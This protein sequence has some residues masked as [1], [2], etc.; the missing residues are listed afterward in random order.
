[1]ACSNDG[2]L[3]NFSSFLSVT[4]QGDVRLRRLSISSE[5]SLTDCEELGL[6]HCAIGIDDDQHARAR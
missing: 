3:N 1:M 4:C 6:T 5:E 2:R